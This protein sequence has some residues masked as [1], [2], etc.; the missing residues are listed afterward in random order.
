MAEPKQYPINEIFG[1]TIQGEGPNAGRRTWFVRFAGCDYDC[2][3]CDTKY[4]VSP[5]YA[6]WSREMLTSGQIMGK[7]IDLG[8][9]MYDMVTLSGGNPALFVDE[10][11]V[12]AFADS[13]IYLAMETQGSRLLLPGVARRIHTLVVSPKPPSSL[14]SDKVDLNTLVQLLTIDRED[15]VSALKYVIFSREDAEWIAAL[16]TDLLGSQF[17]YPNIRRYLSVGTV[18]D[19]KDSTT[20][21]LNS[22]RN[23]ADLIISDPR[24]RNFIGLPQLHVLLWG[25]KRGV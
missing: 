7:L 13:S 15:G 6:G 25:Q 2:Y 14:M 21:I 16:E 23:V 18:L 5:K 24:F 8:I 10:E 20:Q 17:A 1:P 4:A 12:E 3:W 22:Y 9:R 19:S 11:L